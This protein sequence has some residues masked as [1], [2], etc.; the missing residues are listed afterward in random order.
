[1]HRHVEVIRFEVIGH[2]A[3]ALERVLA[4]G[5]LE[6]ERLA[7][8][9]AL[10]WEESHVLHMT[11]AHADVHFLKASAALPLPRTWGSA[12]LLWGRPAG[13]GSDRRCDSCHHIRHTAEGGPPRR[14][15][16]TP[17]TCTG[18]SV[19]HVSITQILDDSGMSGND[20]IK[21]TFIL[22][23]SSQT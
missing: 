10:L 7:G 5:L 1:M 6:A 3:E 15:A 23:M 16:R 11:P 22:L 13:A 21:R 19:R 18:R 17:C 14:P 2:L 20:D 12:S 8:F 4:H 9:V